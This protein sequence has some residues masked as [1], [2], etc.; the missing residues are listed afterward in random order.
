MYCYYVA[1]VDVLYWLLST[2]SYSWDI[3]SR[4]ALDLGLKD[5]T[6]ALDVD[7]GTAGCRTLL[8][9]DLPSALPGRALEDLS[10]AELLLGQ[11][12]LGANDVSDAVTARIE[13]RI[14]L[15]SY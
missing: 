2:C 11:T 13:I 12:Q 1:V 3:Q 15:R 4:S 9:R 7:R 6:V 14:L 8:L 5:G 10:E